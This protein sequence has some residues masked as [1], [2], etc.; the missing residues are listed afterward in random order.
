MTFTG[1]LISYVAD[2]QLCDFRYKIY[3]KDAFLD[4]AA[5]S[6]QACRYGLWEYSRHPNYF[7]EIV[8]WVGMALIGCA[9]DSQ[10]VKT[11]WYLTFAGAIGIWG[12]FQFYSVPEMDKRNLKN[13]DGYETIMKEVSSLFPFFSTKS[14]LK[15]K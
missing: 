4:F 13:R 6:R 11:P 1:I 2:K 5:G 7:G 14:D 12:L 10:S 8:Y 9:G 15:S 3:G